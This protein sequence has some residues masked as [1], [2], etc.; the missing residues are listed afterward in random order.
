M[1]NLRL[2][3]ASSSE[4]RQRGIVPKLVKLLGIENF[5]VRPWYRQFPNGAF[6]LDVLIGL[7][8]TV[9]AALFI[10]G[11]DDTREFRGTTG[12][13]TRDNVILE[14]GIFISEL[15]R[16]R[17]WILKEEG[18]ELP[19]D[20]SGLTVSTF[21]STSDIQLEASLELCAQEIGSQWSD[22]LPGP[23]FQK[24]LDIDDK[25]VGVANTLRTR[26]DR[27]TD[28]IN[29]LR[30]LDVDSP[31]ATQPPFYF[32]SE[33]DCISTYSEA[34]SIVN[35]RFWTTTFLSSSFWTKRDTR[36]LDANRKMM[37]RLSLSDS[38][39][40]RRLFLLEQT[41]EKE[42]EARKQRLMYLRR[43]QKLSEVDR[44]NVGLSH[45]KRNVSSLIKQ[46][47]QVKVVHKLDAQYK[48]FLPTQMEFDGQ[49]SEIAIYDSS[50]VDVFS[51]GRVGVISGVKLYCSFANQFDIYLE[52]AEQYFEHLWSKADSIDN[53]LKKLEAAHKFA[54]TRINYTPN[55]LAKYEFGLNASDEKL[56]TIELS[57]VDEFLRNNDLWGNVRRYLD[58][59]TC[60]ARY[61]RELFDAVIDGGSIIGIDNDSDSVEF[62]RSLVEDFIDKKYSSNSNPVKKN[63]SV[64]EAD[65]CESIDGKHKLFDSIR[66]FDLITCM[67]GTLSHFGWDRNSGYK[68]S[69]QLALERMAQLLTKDGSLVIGTWSALACDQ[70]HMLDIYKTEDLQRLSKWTP[71]A[72]EIQ[73][74]LK[75]VGLKIEMHSR[76]EERMDFLVCKHAD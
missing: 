19:F 47:C 76:P 39:D 7:P 34:L 73:C 8:E 66:S 52:G 44:L 31:D 26:N 11:K 59:G 25:T 40:V 29:T 1:E 21:D 22:M 4:A 42:A 53:F 57:R 50:R 32:D 9:D 65:F 41:P 38:S 35:K 67:L 43:H 74:R 63:I 69:L 72:E 75:Q 68:D 23:F 10:F 55:Y 64:L 27:N 5:D 71:D 61:P 37:N 17:V 36:V 56:K 70:L 51:G 18:V 6:A 14:Y 12:Y 54:K 3:V 48:Q 28:M 62:A 2:Y 30:T 20:L 60:T 45:L 16:K 33:N 15:G 46:G 58:I 49:D 24:D 13:T